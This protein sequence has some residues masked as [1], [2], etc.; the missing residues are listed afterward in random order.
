MQKILVPTDFSATAMKA[1]TYAAEIAQKTGATIFLLHAMERATDTILEP[2]AFD[3]KGQ[4][5]FVNERL[6][7]L[8]TLQKSVAQIYPGIKI[9]TELTKGTVIS[10]ILDFAE[11]QQVD[12]IV[13][14]TTGASG[15]KE[16]F[17]GSV[18]AGTIGKTKI[19]VLTVP[20]S[21]EMEVPDGILFA[22]SHF[23]ENKNLL[24]PVVELAKLYGA[25]IHVAVFVE[26]EEALDY[27]R[28]VKRLN[29]Y[30]EYLR[31]TFPGIKFKGEVL[32][33]KDFELT[34]DKYDNKNELDMIAM[35]T[36]P[37]NF[38]E[39][40]MKKSATKKMAFHSVIP[41]LAI[42]AK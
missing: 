19:P 27:M 9:E 13:M 40:L 30:M 17:M 12:L 33:G 14:G 5:E 16:F 3:I 20:C 10:S 37:K 32:E 2:L 36:Y 42:P 24:N 4:E 22:T 39:R 26:E 29:R 41:L 7:L 8:D 1:V 38:L 23:E 31:E 25:V 11:G 35:I 21:Y 34:I 18:A 15:L 28:N 6:R